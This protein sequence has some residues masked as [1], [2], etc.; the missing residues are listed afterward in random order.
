MK[1]I[2]TK[3]PSGHVGSGHQL[4]ET[5]PVTEYAV[6]GLP[7]GEE[8]R[9]KTESPQFDKWRIYRIKADKGGWWGTTYKTADEA[10]AALQKEYDS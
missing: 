2:L 1:C 3:D 7:T 4:K 8:A 9:L 6:H 5:D 10:L